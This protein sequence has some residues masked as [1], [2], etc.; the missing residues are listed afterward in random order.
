MSLRRAISVP[1]GTKQLEHCCGTYAPDNEVWNDVH[2][3]KTEN[4][5]EALLV[6]P[7]PHML[8]LWNFK[9]AKTLQKSL[10]L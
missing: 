4:K 7:R 6:E 3:H 9:V 8:L 2:L 5:R 1:G 10:S